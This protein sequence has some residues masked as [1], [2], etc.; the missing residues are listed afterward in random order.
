M[1]RH[2]G[3]CGQEAEAQMGTGRV[4]AVRRHPARRISRRGV[5]LGLA[6]L[7]LIASP[8]SAIDGTPSDDL[9]VGVKSPIV[10]AAT[11][12][13]DA[14]S[15]LAPV[16]ARPPVSPDAMWG[17]E[18]ATPET[19]DYAGLPGRLADESLHDLWFEGLTFERHDDLVASAQVYERIVAQVPEESYTYWRIARNYWRTGEALDL[20]LEDER[21]SYFERAERWAAR[22]IAVDPE[23]A[24]CML[25]KFVAMGRKATTLGLWSAAKSAKEMSQLVERGIDLQ[26][27]HRDEPGNST[28]G[29]LYYSGAVFYRVVPDSWWVKL[30]IGVRGDLDRS[31]EYIREAVALSKGRV[32]YRVELGATLLCYGTRK[33]KKKL[34]QEGIEVLEEARELRPYLSTDHLDLEHAGLLIESPDRACGYS[35]DGFIDMD[36]AIAKARVSSREGGGRS[37][38]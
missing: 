23:C 35:R 10:P 37:A 2:S 21:M 11:L 38:E 25:W 9:G 24:P 6:L 26:P 33:N 22:G 36:E 14:A 30:L 16:S 28:L 8:A 5:F 27:T 15:A 12:E 31:L 17:T 1:E 13:I 34:L 20:E 32:D 29:N 4:R 18:T 7:G 3:V 19:F